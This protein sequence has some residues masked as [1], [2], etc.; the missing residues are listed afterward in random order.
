MELS[1]LLT[2]HCGVSINEDRYESLADISVASAS[3][4]H[5]W[6]ESKSV[7]PCKI[8]SISDYNCVSVKSSSQE[9]EAMETVSDAAN[10]LRL[11][12]LCPSKSCS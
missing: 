8:C 6:A 11:S 7:L 4:M 2:P 12:K 3:L 9:R 5:C 10:R 1:K